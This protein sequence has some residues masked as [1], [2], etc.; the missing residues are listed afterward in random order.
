MQDT[1]GLVGQTLGQYRVIEQIGEGG[2]ATVF[3][4]YQPG[5]NREV[6]LKVLPPHFAK[7]ADF[8]ER[9][10]REAQAIGNLH[11][12]NILPVYD[13]GQDKGYS[14]LAMRYIPNARTLAHE[15]KQP[16]KTERM[17]EVISQIAGALEHAHKAGIIHRDVKP[18][19]VLL[20]GPWALLSDFGLAKMVENPVELTGTGVGMGT[21]AYMSPEQGMGKKVDHR[22]DIY[23]LGI[24]LYEMLTGQIPHKAE[25]PIATVMKRINEPL[26]LPRSLNPK[27]PEAVE[28]V[29]LKAL[30][31]DP[32]DR[33]D[34]AGELATALK[35]AFGPKP[36]EVLPQVSPL[37]G[38][39]PAKTTASTPEPTRV[40]AAPPP[41]PAVKDKSGLPISILG[42]GVVGLLL[43][44]ILV[45]IGV[46][47]FFQM[48]PDPE[49][50]KNIVVVTQI[51]APA[52]ATSAV[53]TSKPVAT[54]GA[55]DSLAPATATPTEA[56][57][58]TSTR[59][60]A[61]ASES[62]PTQEPAAEITPPQESASQVKPA[63]AAQ[64]L[65]GQ[66]VA[67]LALAEA[68]N[69]Q[70]DAVLS[71]ISTSGLG[72]LDAEGKSTDWILKFWSPSSKGLNTLMFMNGALVSSPTNLP[73]PKTTVLD[74]VILDTKRLY[75][76]G[77]KAGAAKFTAEGYRPMAAITPYPLDENRL[78]WY[79]NYAGGDYRVVFTVV[80]DAV[81]GEVIQAIALE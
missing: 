42:F 70:A 55:N 20:D 37:Y 16:L 26:P 23:A 39:A 53:P 61:V 51:A 45:G 9:F 31:T 36:D 50:A 68:Q 49:T 13:S 4:A 62:T 72:P 41:A 77:E 34:Q 22:T 1:S 43:A 21:P 28:R 10:A 2:M 15:M 59:A 66:E 73:V 48:R 35:A 3:K 46:L 44:L 47:I 58:A 80:I 32:A 74:N 17:I 11:H 29:L 81:S 56:P 38:A 75:D 14:Y 76:I 69:W 30:A 60:A 27:I 65:T 25:T 78:T 7:Q 52:T 8:T 12:P 5:L 19:N 18:T 79:L 63:P 33:F 67:E 71:E 57:P 6:A 24:I 64:A 40:A 54:T